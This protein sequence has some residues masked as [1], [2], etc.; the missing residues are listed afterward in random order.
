MQRAIQH[1]IDALATRMGDNCEE[2]S[3]T[4][5]VTN[6][7]FGILEHVGPQEWHWVKDEDAMVARGDPGRLAYADRACAE[8]DL[9]KMRAKYL[10]RDLT[11]VEATPDNKEDRFILL[12]EGDGGR[13]GVK[14]IGIE[15]SIWN[16]VNNFNEMEVARGAPPATVDEVIKA[17]ATAVHYSLVFL[18][19]DG[20]DTYASHDSDVYIK[21][22]DSDD[23]SVERFCVAL[24][25]LKITTDGC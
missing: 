19:C 9:N 25:K 11:V 1:T 3:S 12:S 8:H 15:Q 17:L 4:M 6:R 18:G 10:E 22:P 23:V 21:H 2:G 14:Y 16:A 13:R 24:L 7:R 5:T 20:G